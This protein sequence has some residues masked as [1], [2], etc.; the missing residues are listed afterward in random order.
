MT[1][2]LDRLYAVE[3]TMFQEQLRHQAFHDPLTGL[4]NRA[5]LRDR[6]EHAQ[7]RAD[8]QFRPL[9]V[10]VINIDKFKVINDSL[11]QQQG[12]ELLQVV[13]E[14]LRGCLRPGDTAARV[15]GDEFTIL[16]EDVT[17]LDEVTA[18]ADRLLLSMHPSRS[19]C[20]AATCLSPPAS[21]SP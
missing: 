2:D 18:V 1:A 13:A 15:G 12:D 10:L 11:G 19:P 3:R 21:A 20:T 14:R 7:A 5:L 6:I 17:H 16:L 8:R 9:G 4:P